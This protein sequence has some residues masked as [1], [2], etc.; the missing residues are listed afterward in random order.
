MSDASGQGRAKKNGERGAERRIDRE[1]ERIFFV[2]F[3]QCENL[4]KNNSHL[5]VFLNVSV[6][7]YIMFS[8]EIPCHTVVFLLKY[9]I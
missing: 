6:Y 5:F 7:T 9:L 1:R 2:K 3:L 4:K 8:L